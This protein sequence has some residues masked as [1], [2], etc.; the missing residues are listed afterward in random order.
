M[1]PGYSPGELQ[2][3]NNQS[4]LLI[5]RGLHARLFN[6][7]NVSHVALCDFRRNFLVNLR[8]I[9]RRYPRIRAAIPQFLGHTVFR[10]EQIYKAL[11]LYPNNDS[12]DR[13]A[14]GMPIIAAT[15]GEMISPT[16]FCPGDVYGAPLFPNCDLISQTIVDGC[17]E[18]LST[19]RDYNFF[20]IDDAQSVRVCYNTAGSTLFH[21]AIQLCRAGN[22]EEDDFESIMKWL[23]KV[24]G[25]SVGVWDDIYVVPG[26]FHGAVGIPNLPLDP[27]ISILQHALEQAWM[28]LGVTEDLIVWH[29]G[30]SPVPDP[31]V[32]AMLDLWT[33]WEIIPRVSLN[34]A[35]WATLHNASLSQAEEDAVK[36]YD[37]CWHAICYNRNGD[38]LFDYFKSLANGPH[39]AARLPSSPSLLSFETPLRVAVWM[40]R[41]DLVERFCNFHPPPGYIIYNPGDVTDV[42][43]IIRSREPNSPECLNHIMSMPSLLPWLASTFGGPDNAIMAIARLVFS[44]FAVLEEALNSLPLTPG[45]LANYTPAMQYLRQLAARKMCAVLTHARPQSFQNPITARGWRRIRRLGG[46]P[47]RRFLQRLIRPGIA[48]HPFRAIGR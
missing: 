1:P 4:N 32:A 21:L 15:R 28:P 13:T 45:T 12:A 3:L 47:S 6:H 9:G 43:Y 25:S 37:T 36:Q 7:G 35:V 8:A 29:M 41:P 19:I 24:S 10:N 39:A 48:F 22:L 27:P 16:V 38:I 33:R 23:I 14:R 20:P 40:N 11:R 31:K 17:L 26:P 5:L 46:R 18:C 30:S 2:T 34:I 44:W 42:D